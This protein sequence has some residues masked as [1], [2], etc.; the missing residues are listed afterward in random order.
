[1]WLGAGAILL[2]GVFLVRTAVEEGWLGP[3]ARCALA[4]LLGLALVA[5][6][7]WL[8]RRAPLHAAAEAMPA[9]TPAAHAWPD[10][11]PGALAAGGVAVL[12]GA[13][14]ATAV[15]YALVPPLLGFALLALAALAGLALALLHGPL[16]AAIGIACAYLTPALVQTEDPSLPGL[17]AYLLIV[18]AAALAVV[19]QV[20]AVWLG[21]VATIAAAGWVVVA[22]LFI[23]SDGDLWAPALFVPAAAA[24]HLALLPGAALETALG[25]RLAWVPFAVLGGAALLLVPG[26]KSLSPAAALL[27]LTPVA[28]WKGIAEP[29]VDR[30]P[31]LAGLFGLLLLLAWRIPAWLPSGETVSIAGVVQGILPLGPWPPEALQPFL[32]AALL[33]AAMHGLAGWWQECR[34]PHPLRWAALLAAVPVLALL[35]AYARVRGFAPDIRWALAAV[36]LAAVLVAAATAAQRAGAQQRAGAHAAGAV[37][38]LALGA[39]MVLS[40]QWLTLAVALFLPPLAWVEARADLPALRRVATAVAGLVLVRL[41]LN[42]EVLDYSFGT[43]PVLNGL[44]LAYG[45]PAAAF[46][47]AAFQFRRR[48][49]DATV[50]VLEAGALAFLTALLLLEARHAMT[51]GDL[52]G[53]EWG[54]PEAALQ[55]C[56]LSLLAALVRLLNRRLGR[57]VLDWGWRLQQLAALGLGLVLL[58]ANPA[59]ETGVA[60]LTTPVLNELLL[61]YA[62]PA[63]LAAAAAQSPEAGR[64]PLFRPALALYALAAGFAWVTLEVRHEFHPLDMSLDLEPVG[65]AELYAYSGAWL[66]FGAFL[67]ALGI[68]NGIP[69]LRLAALAMLGLTILKAFLVDMAELQGLWRVLSFLGLGLAL[70]AL[71]WVYRR[72][73]VAPATLPPAPAPQA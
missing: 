35:V 17:F 65:A 60:L 73:V 48:A 61:A 53:E 45:V 69:A 42:Q 4:G 55:L 38:A 13:A 1:M 19:R 62:L 67:L 14:Y 10:L 6:A 12:F 66:G 29:R 57:V 70:I 31:W 41:L 20:A 27:L 22:G 37:A 5:A 39:A 32:G 23:G 28:V 40:S 54:F 49:D 64:P 44:L 9:E 30:L 56:A 63:A 46:A 21:W 52:A 50:A 26:T 72:F 15:L 43:M 71:G 2:A 34:A 68:R 59:F 3:E 16:V 33:L 24:L 8:R 11:A 47:V 7:E 58:L 25:R 51:S 18:T 36:A